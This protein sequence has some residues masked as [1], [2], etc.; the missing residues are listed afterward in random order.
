[1]ANELDDISEID[2]VEQQNQSQVDEDAGIPEKFKGKSKAD[3]AKAYLEAEKTIGRQ[4]QEVGEVRRLADELLKQQL[5]KKAE[6]EKPVEVDFFENP[7][8]AVRKAVESNPTVLQ[9]REYAINAQK[10][11]ARQRMY[12]KHPDTDAII[13][14]PEFREYV[15]KSKVRMELLQR[16]DQ[17]YDLD[18]ADELLSTF[19]EMKAVKATRDK[20]TSDAELNADKNARTK[21]LN[22]A[23]VDSGGA[24]EGSKKVYR[25]SDLINL[26][27]RDPR[28]FEAM[29]EEINRAY[30]EGRVR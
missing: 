16:A 24:G 2:A 18:A 12:Q 17:N 19:K 11:Q 13:A 15:G 8:E 6:V 14:D 29:S 30:A 28:K 7:Q 3:I 10:E 22:A 20:E 4:A 1:M 5:T 25:R 9:A 21:Q 23:F 26:R 27:L